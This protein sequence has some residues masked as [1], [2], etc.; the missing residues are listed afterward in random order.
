M[1]HWK[2][3]SAAEKEEYKVIFPR[4]SFLGLGFCIFKIIGGSSSQ[5][6]RGSEEKKKRGGGGQSG[7]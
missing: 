5:K 6:S 3:L 1:A 7:I 2:G 4:E